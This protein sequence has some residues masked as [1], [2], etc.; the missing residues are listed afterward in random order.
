[1]KKIGM[2]LVCIMFGFGIFF[3]WQIA[4]EA[5][6]AVPVGLAKKIEIPLGADGKK[7]ADI[8]EAEGIIQRA[9]HYRMYARFDPTVSRAKAG[10][11][12]L[13]PGTNYHEIAR[14]LALGP[15]R[16]ESEITMIEG[17]TLDQFIDQLETDHGIATTTTAKR[18]GRSVNR[19][20]FD[21]EYRTT[22]TFLNNL[23]N[24]RSLEGYL[25]P[26]TYR[27]W[28]DQLPNGLITKQL[29]EFEKRF[30]AAKPGPQSAPL[31]NLD[32]VIILA[33]IVQD[34]V[35]SE[36]DMKAVAGIFLNR[37]R[38]GMALQ[39]DATINYLTGSGRARSTAKD[40]TIDSPWNTY[41]YRG[42]PPSPIGNPGEAAIKAV[43]D[44]E[45]NEYRYFL[46]D[47]AGKVYYGRTLDE[48]IENRQKAGYSN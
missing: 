12:A 28:T 13:R 35:R 21:T 30:A 9:F 40:L 16:D 39:S 11:Y 33:S 18:I 34:E 24:N 41:K 37:L 5:Y 38:D 2:I 42:L 44:P 14:T 26:N 46:T 3:G 48:H 32:E 1:M 10:V 15:K 6:F 7:I 27:V 20:T 23:P 47:E 17:E 19:G 43:L 22:Y 31:K 29:E 25:F 4:N 45:P 36:A 8:L